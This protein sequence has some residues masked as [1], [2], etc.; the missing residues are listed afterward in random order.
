MTTAAALGLRL[1]NLRNSRRLTLGQLAERSGVSP[2]TISKIENGVLSPTLDK[3]LRLADGLDISVNH[4]IGEGDET[5]KVPNSRL[6]TSHTG[7]GI[8]I[9]TPN[10]EYRYLCSALKNKRM[11]PIRA[12]IKAATVQEFGPL[13]RHGGEEFLMVMEGSIEVHSEF[14][15]P[16][17]LNRGESIYLDSTMGHAYVNTGPHDAE[18]ICIC[19]E[20]QRLQDHRHELGPEDG[21]ARDQHDART[22]RGRSS[23][24]T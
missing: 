8:V 24:S 10:Y 19:T 22:R 20:P 2:S 13:E 21:A 18:V 14:Y 12:R 6:Q 4:L 7:E 23:Y 3:V 1:R 9:D 5:G 16:I 11:V 15:A 17:T